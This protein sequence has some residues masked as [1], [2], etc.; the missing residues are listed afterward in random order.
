MARPAR[1]WARLAEAAALAVLLAN[2][3]AVALASLQI[4]TLE[5]RGLVLS[6][7]VEAGQVIALEHQN[8]IYQALVR[9]TYRVGPRGE[10]WQVMLESPSAGV[11]EYH[12]YDP[13]PGGRAFL[14][15]PLGA[16]RLRSM[17]YE[18]HRLLVDGRA[19]ALKDLAQPGQ[20]L[21]LKVVT[22]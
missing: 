3:Q 17:S 9:E 22:P 5:P 18:H 11:F 13:P 16:L 15:R 4:W 20:P 19:I 8:S 1:R 2:T 12:G 14:E 10:L 21:V 7:A 6:L